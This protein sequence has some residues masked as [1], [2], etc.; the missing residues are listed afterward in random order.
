MDI[1][2]NNKFNVLFNE[3]DNESISFN[4]LYNKFVSIVFSITDDC[5]LTSTE[6]IQ[7]TMF[8]MSQK[9][10]DLQKLKMKAYKDIKRLGS[11]QDLDNFM[12]L[13]SKYVKFSDIICKKCKH[14]RKLDYL[15]WII[16]F[17]GLKLVAN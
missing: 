13:I 4:D 11:T 8:H 16:F 17:I 10:F 15:H 3:F 6:S 14:F 12:K 5:D 1:F 9:I 7:K 2:D